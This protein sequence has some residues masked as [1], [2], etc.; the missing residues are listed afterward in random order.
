MAVTLTILGSGTSHGVPM[1]CCD[2]TTC[3]STDPHD[4]RMRPSALFTVG[5]TQILVDTTPEFRLQALKARLDHLD[6]VLFTHSH[7]DHIVGLDDLRRYSTKLGRALD[8]YGNAETIDRLQ[9]MFRYAFDFDPHY[10]S[11]KPRLVGHTPEGPF[12]AAGVPVTPIP[13]LHGETEVW[14]YRIG[15]IAYCT[16][17][18]FIPDSSLELLNDLD[19]LILDAVRLRPHPTHYHVDAAI[20]VAQHIGARQ[21]YFTHIAHEI[22]HAAITPTLPDRIALAYDGL[23][24]TSEQS[25][26]T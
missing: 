8:V 21:T 7:A 24:C 1:V 25:V 9:R 26:K 4:Q 14:G 19:V 5:L 17:C 22:R 6:A 16:D 23:V 2:C 18:S 13:Y 20:E 15:G 11:E 12:E 10:P 3:T